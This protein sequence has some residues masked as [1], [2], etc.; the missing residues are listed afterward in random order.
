MTDSLSL[1]VPV[2]NEEENLEDFIS[3]VRDYFSNF[4]RDYEVIFVD[5]GS[6]DSSVDVINS[7]KEDYMRIVRHKEN[8]GYGEALKT[9]FR[10]S[11]FEWVA[12]IDGDNQFEVETLDKLIEYSED[13]DMVIG[14]RETREDDKSRIIVGKGFN[15]L[16]KKYLGIKYEDVDCGIKLFRK[17]ILN[18]TNLNSKR[19]LDAE[20]LA[21]A[22][23]KDFDI[24]QVDVNHH[25]RS[26]GESEASGLLGVRIPL[27]IITLKELI[28]IKK[29]I[30]S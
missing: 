26:E 19:T 6:V 25:E 9:G 27:I 2:Y 17:E 28:Q 4:K 10:K 24:K 13:Y 22:L 21:K 20:L 8:K 7:F 18:Q 14:N 23:D 3:N 12:Y 1:V 15:V 11:R 29:E 30:K 5:D 16:V